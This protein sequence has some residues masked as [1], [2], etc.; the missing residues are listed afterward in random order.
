MCPKSLDILSRAVN[1]PIN[2]DATEEELDAIAEKLL[3]V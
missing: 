3:N 2:P 1:V